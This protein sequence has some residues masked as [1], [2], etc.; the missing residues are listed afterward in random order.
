MPTVRPP[1]QPTRYQL[2]G[3]HLFHFEERPSIDKLFNYLNHVEG[4][5]FFDRDDLFER[6]RVFTG[7]LEGR[8]GAG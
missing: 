8:T 6:L 4:N 1:M 2:A 5:V 7:S 3:E